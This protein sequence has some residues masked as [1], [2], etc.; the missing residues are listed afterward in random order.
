[1]G[2]RATVIQA[3]KCIKMEYKLIDKMLTALENQNEEQFN[4]IQETYKLKLLQLLI[5]TSTSI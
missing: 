3:I 5:K 2:I 4:L 1:M